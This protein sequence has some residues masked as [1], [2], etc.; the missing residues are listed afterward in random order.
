MGE[1]IRVA[2]STPPRRWGH[3]DGWRH[4]DAARVKNH[5]YVT[6]CLPNGRTGEFLGSDRRRAS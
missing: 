3:R 4:G 6:T 1:H 2:Q 5:P